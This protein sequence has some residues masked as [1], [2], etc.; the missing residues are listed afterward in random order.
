[1][2]NFKLSNEQMTL[3]KQIKGIKTYIKIRDNNQFEVDKKD[4]LDFQIEIDEAI[5]SMG[6][7]EQDRL[8]SLGCKLQMLYDEINY[9]KNNQAL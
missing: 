9:Q 6:M 2:F 4:I 7:K 8:T 3:L 1:M 5:I